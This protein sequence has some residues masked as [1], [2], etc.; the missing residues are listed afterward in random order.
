LVSGV[1]KLHHSK[2]SQDSLFRAIGATESLS[3]ILQ[4]QL[5]VLR[6]LLYQPSLKIKVIVVRWGEIAVSLLFQ[7]GE[8]KAGLS[9]LIEFAIGLKATD[10]LL[11]A[12]TGEKGKS[13]I[14]PTFFQ[15]LTSFCQRLRAGSA[16]PKKN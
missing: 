11:H 6:R 9:I 4:G 2:A 1:P 13:K 3:E 14:P 10:P 12:L 15:R 8:K 5:I 16:R 7:F